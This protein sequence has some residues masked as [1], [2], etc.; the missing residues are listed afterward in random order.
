MRNVAI[1]SKKNAYWVIVRLNFLL[2]QNKGFKTFNIRK[3]KSGEERKLIQMYR[4]I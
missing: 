3:S 1:N 4:L 2:Y